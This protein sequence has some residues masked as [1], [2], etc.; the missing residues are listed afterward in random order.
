MFSL[1]KVGIVKRLLLN[2]S[3]EH[4][5][6]LH[7]LCYITYLIKGEMLKLMN[8]SLIPP[9]QQANISCSRP[10]VVVVVQVDVGYI[11]LLQLSLF[12]S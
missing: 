4:R 2:L 5:C 9:G 3:K 7:I 10:T 6:L 12:T 8:V 11:Q 1:D